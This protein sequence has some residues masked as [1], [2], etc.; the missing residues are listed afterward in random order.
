MLDLTRRRGTETEKVYVKKRRDTGRGSRTK[1]LG[2]K[3]NKKI[4]RERKIGQKER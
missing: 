2:K 1:V 4:D 3:Q